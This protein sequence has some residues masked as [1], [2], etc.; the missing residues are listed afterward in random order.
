MK[1]VERKTTARRDDFKFGMWITNAHCAHTC[2]IGRFKFDFK[3][4]NTRRVTVDTLNRMRSLEE[5]TR[6]F[7]FTAVFVGFVFF[8]L[9]CAAA[10][11][12]GSMGMQCVCARASAFFLFH[13]VFHFLF[14]FH[15]WMSLLCARERH[16]SFVVTGCN[17]VGCCARHFCSSSYTLVELLSFSF[18]LLNVLL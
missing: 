1:R 9:R 2:W 12:S 14:Y 17:V 15:R 16:I 7:R 11:G 6:E 10:A 5:N 18:L 3:V 4:A 8:G 13:F